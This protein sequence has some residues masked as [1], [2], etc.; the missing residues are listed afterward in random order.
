MPVLVLLSPSASFNTP[1]NSIPLVAG[2]HTLLVPL[3]LWQSFSFSFLVS[4][5]HSYPLVFSSWHIVL[6]T[7]HTI[8]GWL[9]VLWGFQL[10]GVSPSCLPNLSSVL[11]WVALRHI[12]FLK[13]NVS[14]SQHPP[15]FPNFFFPLYSLYKFGGLTLHPLFQSRHLLFPPCGFYL[16]NTQICCLIQLP[17]S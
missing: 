12:A 5:S 8:P 13:V 6:L 10:L 11:T 9:K 14:S 2:H 3:F 7:L 15:P 17:G 1:L 4:S 16:L